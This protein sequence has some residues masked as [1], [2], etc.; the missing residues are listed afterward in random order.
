MDFLAA[1]HV[2]IIGLCSQVHRMVIFA[3][4]QLSCFKK[5]RLLSC[6]L[7]SFIIIQPV[8]K[9]FERRR[10][11]FVY[12]YQRWSYLLILLNYRVNWIVIVHTNMHWT[13]ARHAVILVKIW[14][15][16]L[17][18]QNHMSLHSDNRDKIL[19]MQQRSLYNIVA[20]WIVKENSSISIFL[21]R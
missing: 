11:P 12:P 4:A 2:R 20:S 16:T 6:C 10:R 9:L 5:Q 8:V 1:D 18:C 3:I 19:Y 17:I 15:T 14:W 21:Y 7:L 13:G